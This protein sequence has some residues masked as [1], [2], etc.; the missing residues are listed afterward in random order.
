MKTVYF[1]DFPSPSLIRLLSPSGKDLLS[2][3]IGQVLQGEVLEV[4]DEGHAV[5]RLKGYDFSVESQAFLQKGMEGEFQVTSLSPRI[6]LRLIPKEEGDLHGIEK[7]L[8]PFLKVHSQ[9]E[10]LSETLSSLLTAD[11]ENLPSPFRETMGR[12]MDLWASFSPSPSLKFE[13]EQI[14]KMILQS[15]LFFE[16]RLKGLMETGDLNRFEKVLNRDLKGLLLKW[17]AEME[18]FKLSQ[19]ETSPRSK[20]MEEVIHLLLR[21]IE[22]HQE[23]TA[24]YPGGTE[25]RIS[26]LLPFWIQGRPQLVDLH[27]TFPSAQEEPSER[28]G[29][30]LLFLLHFV[31]WGRM[32][33]EVRLFGKRLY[34]QFL[35]SSDPVASFFHQELPHLQRALSNLGYQTEI[36][37]STQASEKILEQFVSEIKRND[38]SLLDLL[39]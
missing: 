23:I 39:V 31:E 37:V 9:M 21:K 17:K 12:L 1:P 24:S 3:Q 8:V 22:S 4:M 16:N 7:K 32:S 5:I 25:E 18:T 35:F 15:G 38:R 27:L 26:L 19:P 13:P 33:I 30:S 34:G 2:L 11:K 20:E 36:H 14:A 28:R 6:I 29:L 10:N